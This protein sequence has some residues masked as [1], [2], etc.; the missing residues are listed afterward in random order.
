ML[1]TIITT[2]NARRDIQDAIDWENMRQPGLAKR[3]LNDLEQK[4]SAI[5]AAPHIG[6]VRYENVRCIATNIFPYLIHYITDEDRQQIVIL[7][8]LH[9]SRKPIW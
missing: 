2:T 7:R 6:S 9:T 4:L 8:V 3:F 5:A 1:Y